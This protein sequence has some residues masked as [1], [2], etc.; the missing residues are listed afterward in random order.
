MYREQVFSCADLIANGTSR[1]SKIR[2]GCIFLHN[3]ISL[4][5]ALLTCAGSY[6]RVS[7]VD[8]AAHNL[9]THADLRLEQTSL[10]LHYANHY[11]YQWRLYIAARKCRAYAQ[12]APSIPITNSTRWLILGTVD[13]ECQCS[14]M[15][16]IVIL[17]KSHLTLF[18]LHYRL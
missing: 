18:A 10:D 6:G 8:S 12:Q 17:T 9:I 16:I 7:P 13:K 15:N 11:S 14:C 2:R 1:I 4:S 5:H 3:A